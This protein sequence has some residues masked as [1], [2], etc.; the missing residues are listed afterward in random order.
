M[1]KKKIYLDHAATTPTDPEVL[2]AMK[3]FFTEKFGNP[4]SI[5]LTG[6]EAL[7]AVDEARQSIA[8]FL[9][10]KESEIVFT[11]GA[12]ESDNL[13][14]R[15]VLSEYYARGAKPQDLHVI[16][17]N[18][19]HPAVLDTCQYVM[20]KGVNVSYLPVNK[21]GIV[22]VGDIKK[23][24][25]YKTVLISIMYV[26]NEIGTIQ[27]IEQIGKFI[28]ELNSRRVKKKLP[29]IIF[30]TD[31][32]QAVNYL[33]CDVNKL[34]VDLMSVSGHKIYGPKGIG[35]LYARERTPIR[36][37]QIGGHHENNLRSGTLNVTGIIGISKA[38]ELIQK[39]HTTGAVKK[40]KKIRN[41]FIGNIKKS[42]DKVTVNGSLEKRVPSNIHLSFYGAEG[43]S[44]LMMLDQKG[45]AVSTGSACASGS[46]EP[47]YVLNAIGLPP[48]YSHGSIRIT[49][50]RDS[51]SI[52]LKKLG[53]TLGN[54]IKKLRQISPLK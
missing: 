17:S 14:I 44:M 32:V 48:E 51:S 49:L 50:G 9:N 35:I 47:S 13:A 15:G 18:I 33:D 6:Q 42:I 20:K 11:S 34:N 46:L 1:N 52:Q 8:K 3:P 40:M 4:A 25:N 16:T 53:N 38:I 21:E 43:E 41:D 37:I 19:E 54:T 39:D 30:H 29:K 24:I 2:K 28:K 23:V 12:T 26:N 5:H 7:S 22:S 31:A 10:S 45:F 27:P 36:S